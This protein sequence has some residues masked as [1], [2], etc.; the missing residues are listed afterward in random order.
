MGKISSYNQGLADPEAML[1][2]SAPAPGKRT[3]QYRMGDVQSRIESKHYLIELGPSFVLHQLILSSVYDS[4][5]VR[6]V[7]QSGGPRTIGG[8]SIT[9]GASSAIIP[10]M[11]GV[12]A[13]WV[14]SEVEPTSAN[15]LLAG[16]GL[17]I[18]IATGVTMNLW[19]QVDL[20]I[21]V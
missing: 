8:M 10:D 20:L 3:K 6:V 12:V 7:L 19:V 1:I 18:S 2:G 17:S 13:D 11:N 21:K 4:T 9:D 14:V 5:I 16:N 15:E